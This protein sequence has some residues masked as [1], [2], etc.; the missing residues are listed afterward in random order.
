MDVCLYVCMIGEKKL[1]GGEEKDE[2]EDEKI[3]KK[4]MVEMLF[5]SS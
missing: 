1:G 3:G 2:D 5:F 4:R